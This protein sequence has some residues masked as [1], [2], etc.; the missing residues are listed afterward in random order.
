MAQYIIAH[1]LGTS[2]N[3]AT[4]FH[5]DGRFVKSCTIPYKVHFFGKNCAEQDP[6]D[7]WAAVCRATQN[8]MEGI[9]K[10][11]VIAI[12]FSAQMQGCLLVDGKGKPLRPSIIWADQRAVKET[13]YL[14]RE[15]GFD[16]MYE[17]TGHRLNP[18]YTLEKI[19]WLKEHEPEIYQKASRSLQAKDYILFRLT[20]EFATDYSDASGTNALDLEHLCWSDEILEASGIRRSLLPEL[21]NSTDIIG[22][23]TKEAAKASGLCEG[24]PVICGG[25]M[26]PAL[27]LA[28]AVSMTTSFLQHLGHRPGS[29]E[30]QKKNSWMKRRFSSA[31]R[32]S[33]QEN[34]CPAE[35]CRRPG[36]RIPIYVDF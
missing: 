34:I 21:H 27:R 11:D 14:N 18:S 6:E 29:A 36:V 33:S 13:E 28:P 1:D 22:K 5:I 31:L 24:T 32:I 30:Q 10:T 17:L 26:A 4:L 7:W 16:R 35:P 23:V 9:E 15:I 25:G 19:M 12:S 2:G 20:G 3:K 8:V